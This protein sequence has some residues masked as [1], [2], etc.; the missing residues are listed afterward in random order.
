[1]EGQL[2]ES[3][4]HSADYRDWTYHLRPGVRWHDGVPVTAGDV[5]FTL[6]LLCQQLAIGYRM[7][8]GARVTEDRER[9]SRIARAGGGQLHLARL[10]LRRGGPPRQKL[11]APIRTG[12]PQVRIEHTQRKRPGELMPTQIRRHHQA[13][14]S[15]RQHRNDAPLANATA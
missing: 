11:G 8:V 15:I 10:S 1:M 14:A 12:S 6:D 3:W 13:E 5:K 7:C 4:E 2:A 9:R